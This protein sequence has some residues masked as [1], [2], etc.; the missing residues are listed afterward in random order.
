MWTMYGFRGTYFVPSRLEQRLWQSSRCRTEGKPIFG[1]N[2]NT[3]IQEFKAKFEPIDDVTEAKNHILQLKQG[4]RS[5][6]SLIADFETW[7]PQTG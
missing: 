5:F 2:W 3:F 7:A 6:V 1:D 4:S